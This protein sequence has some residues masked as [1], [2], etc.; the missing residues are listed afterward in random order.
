[1]NQRTALTVLLAGGLVTACSDA[2]TDVPA[3]PSQ[4]HA[5]AI[6]PEALAQMAGDALPFSDERLVD[7]SSALDDVHA[8]LLPAVGDDGGL[9]E[10]QIAITKIDQAMGRSDPHAMIVASTGVLAALDAAAAR[11]ELASFVAEFDAIRLALGE[12]RGSAA[13]ELKR[14]YS[15]TR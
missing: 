13:A 1:M 4:V 6:S 9:R 7:L 10:L 12:L 2:P 11:T 3:D 8:R 5:E 14:Q 15:A